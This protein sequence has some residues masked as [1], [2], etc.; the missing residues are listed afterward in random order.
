MH[1]SW[2]LVSGLIGLGVWLGIIEDLEAEDPLVLTIKRGIYC[3]QNDEYEKAETILHSALQMAQDLSFEEAQV[4]VYDILANNYFKKQ[5]YKRAEQLF[6][7]VFNYVLKKGMPPN[8]ES[9][10]E[11]SIKLSHIYSQLG[12]W[13]KCQKGFD[14]C[15]TEQRQRVTAFETK[16]SDELNEDEINSL[17]LL[18]MCHDYY[19]KH[20][21][22]IGRFDTSIDN[23]KTAL[24]ICVKINGETHPQTLVLMNDMS[25][26]YVHKKDY[27]NA[28]SYQKKV[29]DGAVRTDDK[30]LAKYYYNMGSIYLLQMNKELALNSCRKSLV[31][32]RESNDKELEG[33]A[34]ECIAQ[35]NI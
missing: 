27:D 18:G 24:D 33:K 11:I 13:D 2:D 10:I 20:L 23:L 1:R 9:L 5:D 29:L 12:E 6:A 22:S 30:N 14:Y 31:L 32:T 35:S 4:Y 34:R 15:L 16:N 25:A 28:L 8:D 19:A 21:G 17:A 26:A 3:M 7:A